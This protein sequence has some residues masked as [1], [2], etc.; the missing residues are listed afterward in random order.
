MAN[1]KNKTQV[2]LPIIE[3]AL[4]Q[5]ASVEEIQSI[6]AIANCSEALLP[7]VVTLVIV[8]GDVA[9]KWI[10]HYTKPSLKYKQIR[11]SEFC[12]HAGIPGYMKDEEGLTITAIIV[13]IVTA[14][15][16]TPKQADA[17]YDI[18]ARQFSPLS[19]RRDPE[20]SLAG[21]V[22]KRVCPNGCNVDEDGYLIIN[23]QNIIS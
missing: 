19:Y 16:L 21:C 20:H 1:N 22:Y 8:L 13:N 4:Q 2:T 18:Y 7:A 14:Y 10:Q 5:T 3:A 23:P 17:L 9:K 6:R 15:G 12:V 11:K